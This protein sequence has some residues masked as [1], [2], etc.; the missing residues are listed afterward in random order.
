M[1]TALKDN[2]N[3]INVAVVMRKHSAFMDAITANASP[4][5][6]HYTFPLARGNK[7]DK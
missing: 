4:P 6:L 5:P 2:G 3:R 7:G 1:M